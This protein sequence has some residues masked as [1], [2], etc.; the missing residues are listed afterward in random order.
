MKRS[1]WFEILL[2]IAVLAI[3]LYAAFSEA[4]N[5]PN[6]WFIRDDAYYYFKVAENIGLG[7]GSTFDGINPTNGYHPLWMLICIPIF[8]LARFDLILPL[9][10]LLIV[11]SLFSIATAIL[12]YRLISDILSPPVG[13][14]IAVYWVFNFYI[15]D[16]F[17]NLGLE[18]GIALFF[19][20]LL[21]YMLCQLERNK[22]KIAVSWRQVAWLSLI[23]ALTMFSRLD[24]VF[25][26]LIIGIWIVFRN[27]PMRYLMPLDIS[28]VIAA[29]LLAFLMRLGLPK[30][31]ESSNAA[32]D[33]IFIGLVVKI[34]IFF[35]MSLYQ[36][37]ATWKPLEMLKN[38][39]LAVIMSSAAVVILTSVGSAL[40]IFPS[41]PRV[42]LLTDAMLTWVALILIRAM[43]FGLR[44][45]D[46]NL[47]A[48]SPPEYFKQHWRQW[49]KESSV[50]YGILGGSLSLYMVWNKLA[51][52]TFTPVSGQIKQWWSTFAINIYG[53]PALS[54]QSFFALTPN[55]DFDAWEPALSLI[56]TW[57]KSIANFLPS[58]ILQ[59][60]GQIRFFI[61]L[62]LLG[63][64]AYLL[65]FLTK[66]QKA[67]A[68]LRIGVIPLFAGSWIQIFSYNSAGYVAPKDWYWLAELILI[69]ILVAIF[70]DMA[71][72]FFLRKSRT[73][74]FGARLLGGLLC[75]FWTMQYYQNVISQMTHQPAP[76]NT[77]YISQIPFLETNTKPGD[78]IGISGGGNIGYFLP[79]RT[80]INMDGLIN[81]YPYYLAMKMRLGPD[82][83]YKEGMR[84][85]FANPDMLKAPPYGGQYAGRLTIVADYGDKDLLKLSAPNP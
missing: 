22:N 67:R 51:F 45:T 32:L 49:I 35:F 75:I 60:D 63:A 7:H 79:D 21:I 70:L 12:L 42:A 83:L 38:I 55:N 54:F 76:S 3:Q 5:F 33:M 27:E 48:Y 72:K 53:P 2:I 64:I 9:R 24:L 16:T 85:I 69:A 41:I 57:N 47:K 68:I 36:Q 73:A 39:F 59:I 37:P 40:N 71:F 74:Y 26:A 66:K 58:S 81:S 52:G 13:M 1:H 31:Y 20:A 50:Y 43:A 23:A 30:Y 14:L 62:A 17:Y 78:L 6:N 15:Q 28:A 56:N 44:R 80:V 11:M 46:A 61:F 19:I 34:P 84:Y 10:V 29:A 77:P 4:H 82:Y 18:S 65:L 25:F 8:T